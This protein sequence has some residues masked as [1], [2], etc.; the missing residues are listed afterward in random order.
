MRT[1]TLH[2]CTVADETLDAM[3]NFELFYKLCKDKPT[4]EL[5]NG[6]PMHV[7]ACNHLCRIYTTTAER[8]Y[9]SKDDVDQQLHFLKKAYEMAKEGTNTDTVRAVTSPKVSQ[10]LHASSIIT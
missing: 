6:Q 5:D 3:D 2:G 7:E 1:T 10:M 8:E 4:W 9:A